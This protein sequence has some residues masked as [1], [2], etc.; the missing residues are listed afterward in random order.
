MDSRA[1]CVLAVVVFILSGGCGG[2]G[3][4]GGDLNVGS[5]QGPI[6][7]NEGASAQYSINASGDTGI[8][9]QWTCNPGSAGT[10]TNATSATCT[11][12]AAAVTADT[13]A[14]IS[15]TVNSD[16]DGPEVAQLNITVADVPVVPDTGWAQ[17]WGGTGA[18]NGLRIAIDG[19]NNIYVIGDFRDT[20][21][22]DPGAGTDEHTSNGE[23]DVYLSRFDSSGNLAWAE[24][25]GGSA[26]DFA[27]GIVANGSGEIYVTGF[28]ESTV[29][30]DPG[31]GLNEHI[32]IGQS[33]V[34]LS[35]FDSN[36]A[37]LWVRTWGSLL[38]DKPGDMAIDSATGDV[39]VTGFYESQ[40]D[41]DPDA[42][43]YTLTPVGGRDVFLTK[44][45]PAGDFQWA[46]SWGGSGEDNGA[47]AIVDSSGNI[48]TGGWFHGTVD[49]DPG[50]G[51]DN[52]AMVGTQDGFL[53]QLDSA[54]AFI[55]ANTWGG[56]G[57]YARADALAINSA[58][59]IFVTGGFDGTVDFL[60]GAGT[61]NHSS[62]GSRDAFLTRYDSAGSYNWTV[63]WGGTGYEFGNQVA[64]DSANAVYIA[65]QF[66]G[67]VD[68]NPGSVFDNHTSQGMADIF[69]SKLDSAG[70]F[71]WAR[72]LG[73]TGEDRGFFVTSDSNNNVYSC[74][75]Y[76][77]TVD[78]DPGTGTDDHVSNG[79]IDAFL[80]KYHP[81]GT[82]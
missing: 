21:D 82:W 70:N 55:I 31:S 78:F 20:V 36:G 35:K 18:D 34:Y 73:S 76:S 10:F 24:T 60:A 9:Y 56:A 28:F 50:S 61:D 75:R 1:L 44:Y 7:V 12:T 37:L 53:S 26:V 66:E 52:H 48:W 29:D 74:G 5:V 40:A 13:S 4:G 47:C 27:E 8:T 16:N 45:N 63:T 14:T 32:P 11:F 42:D 68:F 77:D 62:N 30:F 41:F 72:T 25:F 65:G 6:S 3:G 19:S 15:V 54:G 33:D 81:D 71:V 79:D 22:F 46:R 39:Y 43:V 49:F 51:T 23:W 57:G 80:L 38:D 69:V 64:I 2:G 59:A 67:T 58:G 17:T